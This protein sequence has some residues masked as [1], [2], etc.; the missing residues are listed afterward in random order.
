MNRLESWLFTPESAVPYALMRIGVGLV[1]FVHLLFYAPYVVFFFSDEGFLPSAKLPVLV[2]EG[3]PLY[4]FWL[5][6][7]AA[8]TW[9][10]YGLTLAVSLAYATGFKT[11]VAGPLLWV[12]LLSFIHRN[13]FI[14]DGIWNLLVAMLTPMMLVDTGAVLSLDARGR[15][16]EATVDSWLGAVLRFQLGVTYLK[17]GFYKLMGSY[18]VKG[19]SLYYVLENPQW[20]RFNYGFWLDQRWVVVV[21]A[22][23]TI[24]TM[25]WELLFPVLVAVRPWRYYVLGFGVF[26]HGCQFV[27][28]DTSVF[29]LL[30]MTLYVAFLPP[31]RV[32]AW[33]NKLRGIHSG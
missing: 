10:V 22:A 25:W 29:S 32:E 18:W 33:V 21:L 19:T 31:E 9:C 12:L 2:P 27:T 5:A 7:S 30:L 23:V 20:R 24:I 4:F 8:A 6:H 16:E 1:A 17:S 13:V 15:T 11:R 3:W 28:I 14:I 26:L